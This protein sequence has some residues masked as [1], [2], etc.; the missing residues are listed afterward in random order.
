MAAS[1]LPAPGTKFGPCPGACAHI[2]CRSSR[3]E[4]AL[5]CIYCHEPIGYEREFYA[6]SADDLAHAACY[7]SAV[8]EEHL[9]QY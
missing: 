9:G 8:E 1:R 3:E 2:D 7:E 5:R 4:A 6:L